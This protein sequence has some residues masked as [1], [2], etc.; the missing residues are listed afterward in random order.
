[1]RR[2]GKFVTELGLINSDATGYDNQPLTVSFVAVP[3]HR[4]LTHHT[5]PALST[6]QLELGLVGLGILAL[7]V[8]DVHRPAVHALGS[9]L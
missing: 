1:M 8:H 4:S 7:H 9:P 2:E 6:P 3:T 5:S